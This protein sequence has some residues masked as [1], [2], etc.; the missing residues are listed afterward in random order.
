MRQIQ[1][2]SFTSTELYP[3]FRKIIN[4]DI[5]DKPFAEGGFGEIYHC[6]AVNG[7]KIGTPQVIKIF[8]EIYHGSAEESLKTIERL[9]LKFKQLDHDLR[10]Q[11]NNLLSEYPAFLAL[12]QFSF[13]GYMNGV[14]VKGFSSTNLLK[15]G[16]YEFEKILSDS[17]LLNKFYNIPIPRRIFFAYQ[18]ASAFKILDDFKYIHADLKPAALFLNLDSQDLAIIDFD[19]GVITE[20]VKDKPS[21][22]GSPNDWVA[23]EIWD[24]QIVMTRGDKINVDSFT[25]RWSV[26][27]GV[28]Y[29][30][31]GI[32]PLFYLQELGPAITK[33]YFESKQWPDA[34]ANAKYFCK[35]NES[36]YNQYLTFINTEI[37]PQ[38][39]EKISYTINFG[40]KTPAARTNYKDWQTVLKSIQ[41]PPIVKYLTFSKNEII[42]GDSLK[43][44]WSSENA[45]S[46]EIENVPG[47]FGGIDSK[48][49]R[50]SK[51]TTYRFSFKG[52][53]GIITENRIVT[54]IPAPKFKTLQS[55]VGKIKKGGSAKLFWEIENVNQT[56]LIGID[57]EPV[58]IPQKG[59]NIVKPEQTTTYKFEALALDNKTSFEKFITI[60][61]F[62]EGEIIQFTVDRQFVFPTIPVT[63]SWKVI[64]ALSV[65]IDGIGPCAFS[66]QTIVQPSIDTEYKLIVT[67][68]FGKVSKSL[69]VKMLPLPVIERIK[70]PTPTF[71]MDTSISIKNLNQRPFIGFQNIPKI[72][73]GI[74]NFNSHVTVTMP[75]F[76][77]NAPL[78]IPDKYGVLAKLRKNFLKSFLKRFS[79]LLSR[80]EKAK[81]NSY[82]HGEN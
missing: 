42:E 38:I 73:V 21:T 18:L 30:I 36:Y 75:K 6:L 43:I 25:D 69:M 23:P 58:T 17:K 16:F 22:W 15:L 52:Y 62:A 29:L 2:S 71:Q 64:N 54:V 55:D 67:D 66:G 4:V 53:Y 46:V 40:Y 3:E 60:E 56:K 57:H 13:T 35:E 19:S 34:D 79:N 12:P 26:A 7:N 39:K 76:V 49:L 24:Q 28:N 31:T 1:I 47:L 74:K 80:I 11:N 81:L 44:A 65:E 10:I 20:T 63:L 48:I 33:M 72:Q 51:T 61:V 77:L 8:K 27:I 70:I 37:P 78:Y 9:Q 82:H 50:P 5:D 14:Q 45:I 59:N 68:N 41:L 32:H